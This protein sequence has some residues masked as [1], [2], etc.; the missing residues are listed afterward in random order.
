MDTDDGAVASQSPDQKFNISLVQLIARHVNMQQPLVLLKRSPPSV[1]F[2]FVNSSCLRS[3]GFLSV[4][5]FIDDGPLL[6]ALFGFTLL[7]LLLLRFRALTTFL[8]FS[9]LAL[10]TR[11]DW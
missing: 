3:L 6:L 5:E 10:F 11:R 4:R 8:S 1:K 7:F 2:L 9:C